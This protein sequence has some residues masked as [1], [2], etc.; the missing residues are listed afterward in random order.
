MKSLVEQAVSSLNQKLDKS[1]SMREKFGD[2]SAVACQVL[3]H[4]FAENEKGLLVAVLESTAY[5]TQLIRF[6]IMK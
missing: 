3:E 4:L 1:A 5:F 2:N 6:E